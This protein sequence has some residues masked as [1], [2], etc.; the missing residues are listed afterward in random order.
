MGLG[1]TMLAIR[2]GHLQKPCHQKKLT[3]LDKDY[4]PVVLSWA[5]LPLYVSCFFVLGFL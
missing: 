3:F 1:N 2:M 5:T 4:L